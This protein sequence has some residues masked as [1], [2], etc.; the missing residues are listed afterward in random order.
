MKTNTQQNNKGISYQFI[1]FK[2]K[3][4]VQLYKYYSNIDYAEDAVTKERIHLEYPKDYNDIYDS[5]IKFGDDMLLSSHLIVESWRLLF[6]IVCTSEQ[7][8]VV[9]KILNDFDSK[10]CVPFSKIIEQ[11]QCSS[12]T[13]NEIDEIKAKIIKSLGVKQSDSYKISCFTETNNSLL[14]WAYYADKYQG[15]CLEFDTNTD[16][17]PFSECRKVQYT[18]NYKSAGVWDDYFIKSEQWSHEQEWRVVCKTDSEYIHAK[19]TSIFLGPRANS[20]TFFRMAQSAISKEIDLYLVVPK[21][22]VYDLKF[23]KIIEKGILLSN[24]GSKI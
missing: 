16:I 19:V 20:E 23:I 17:P 12:I 6:K 18:R 24:K 21:N 4:N 7:H 10:E 3:P 8:V 9:E 15:V 14:M 2:G 11:M 5:V 13:L 22:D 1:D